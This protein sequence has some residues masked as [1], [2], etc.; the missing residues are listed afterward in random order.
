MAFWSRFLQL[1]PKYF[2]E[3]GRRLHSH[4]DVPLTFDFLWLPIVQVFDIS[5]APWGEKKGLQVVQVLQV[6]GAERR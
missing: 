1:L 3:M 5:P 2:V 4:A 6:R